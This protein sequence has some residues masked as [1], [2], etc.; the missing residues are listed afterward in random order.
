[1]VHAA[2]FEFAVPLGSAIAA[3]PLSVAP[4]AVKAT[5]PVGA[6]PVTVA[7]NVT[8]LPAVA[9][10]SELA[11]DMVVAARLL[12]PNVTASM[13]VVLSLESVPV[14]AMVWVPVVGTENGMLKVAKLVL[15][16]KIT[17]PI[18]APSTLTCTGWM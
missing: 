5:L 11:R 17:L 14:K 4:S 18:C 8:L 1:M 6:L 16:G 2:L 9:G 15:A 7:V 13:K 12:G 3:Q 10:L